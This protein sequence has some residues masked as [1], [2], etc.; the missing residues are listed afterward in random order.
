LWN[1]KMFPHG[2]GRS[3]TIGGL[4]DLSATVLDVLGIAKPPQWQGRSLLQPP[5]EGRR[6]YFYAA[7]DGYQLAV[8]ERNWKYII[9]ATRGREELYDL[10]TDPREQHN[11]AREH[12]TECA[13]W[14]N[15]LAAWA[16]S[17]SRRS[18]Q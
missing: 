8:R 18:A 15:R 10:A 4:I 16:D 7:N 5:A 3:S 14:R 6:A 9:D 12:R 11:V 13:Q 1:P 2:G 17:T